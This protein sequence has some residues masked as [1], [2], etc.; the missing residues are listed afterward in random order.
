MFLGLLDPDPSIFKQKNWK[1]L[2]SYCCRLFLTLSLQN[3]VNV[4]SKRNKQINIFFHF[5]FFLRLEGQ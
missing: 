1:N 2:D 4:P 3:D 5:F